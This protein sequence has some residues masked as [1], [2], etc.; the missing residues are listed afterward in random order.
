MKFNKSKFKYSSS[1][2]CNRYLIASF[3]KFFYWSHIF[4]QALVYIINFRKILA[5]WG[6]SP[7]DWPAGPLYPT[8]LRNFPFRKR[9]SPTKPSWPS[10]S[11]A[12]CQWAEAACTG[13][14]SSSSSTPRPPDCP[15]HPPCHPRCQVLAFIYAVLTTQNDFL[16]QWL[17]QNPFV[18]GSLGPPASP[19]TLPR[20][21]RMWP[22]ARSCSHGISCVP[23]DGY[24]QL[25]PQLP[26]RAA[27]QI[28]AVRLR[29]RGQLLILKT[30]S[31]EIQNL[32][33]WIR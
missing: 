27:S 2:S 22:L 10:R 20:P 13:R 26:A 5:K 6:N 9:M 12:T 8:C 31:G 3:K 19:L 24:R 23:S 11:P 21:G 32:T 18:I 17:C 7:Y 16:M 15:A 14:P 1:Q 25:L 28:P 29:Q 33:E 30:L 4:K